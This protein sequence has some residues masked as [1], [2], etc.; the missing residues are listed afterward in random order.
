MVVCDNHSNNVSFFKKLHA[1]FDNDNDGIYAIIDMKKYLSYAIHLMK[2]IKNNLLNFKRFLF[3]PFQLNQ[4]FD[5]FNVGGVEG[6]WQLFHDL[7]KRDFSLD[8]N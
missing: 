8:A 2:N 4:F 3:V 7:F 5:S 6:T 1:A